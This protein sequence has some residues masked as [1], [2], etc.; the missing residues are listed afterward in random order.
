MYTAHSI[1]Q[2]S[3]ISSNFVLCIEQIYYRVLI[4]MYLCTLRMNV[5]YQEVGQ[6]LAECQ[7]TWTPLV[8]LYTSAV[9]VLVDWSVQVS[10]A[11][12]VT[13]ET[14]SAL[15]KRNSSQLYVHR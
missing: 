6:Y 15:Y 11:V 10:V 2:K 14:V 12:C 9:L 8:V 1:K 5:L 7:N 13:V 4:G 3:D